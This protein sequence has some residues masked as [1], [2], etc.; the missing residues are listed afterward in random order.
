MLSQQYSLYTPED[1][2][3]WSAL[4]LRQYEAVHQFASK[5]FLAGMQKLHFSEGKIPDF[6]AINKQLLPLNGWQV[7]AVPG[8]IDNKYFFEQLQQKK[9]GATYWI[10]KPAQMDYL[11]EP[12][13][14]H[15]VFGHVP[16]LAEPYFTDYLQKLAA[17]ASKYINNVAVV[18][19]IARLYWY[20]VEFGLIWEEG[21]LKIYGAGILSSIA[22]TQYCYSNVPQLLP[23]NLANIVNTPYIKDSFQKQYFV[24]TSLAQLTN[25]VAE[26]A[27]YIEAHLTEMLVVG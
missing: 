15:D 25:S 10:R 12:D 4:Y 7:Y 16:M 6:E 1:Q 22:E 11:E 18:E 5:K 21:K 13:M 24:L 14:F 23:F 20:T 17:I 3:T 9:F 8:L 27:A 19:A 26:L 2:Q